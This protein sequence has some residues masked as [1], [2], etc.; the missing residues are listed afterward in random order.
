MTR[1]T[2]R[3]RR[4]ADPAVIPLRYGATCAQIAWTWIHQI[5]PFGLSPSP[6]HPPPNMNDEM[7]RGRANASVQKMP[8]P[9]PISVFPL[10]QLTESCLYVLVSC[11]VSP[12]TT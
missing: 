5:C 4:V 7:S 10:G 6:Y 3:G 12:T 8:A 9:P 2:R 11:G 1:I